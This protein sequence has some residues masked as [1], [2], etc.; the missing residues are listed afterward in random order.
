MFSENKKRKEK[1][2]DEREE[3]IYKHTDKMFCRVATLLLNLF[4]QYSVT[5]LTQVS[6]YKISLW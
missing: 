5:Y 1:E 4:G 6:C 3:N 2:R